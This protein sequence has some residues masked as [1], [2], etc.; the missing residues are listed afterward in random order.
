MIVVLLCLI[1]GGGYYAY[2]HLVNKNNAENEDS[3][4][5]KEDFVELSPKFIK[6]IEKY[7]QLGI[8]SEGYAAVCKDGKWGYHSLRRTACV[9]IGSRADSEA[10]RRCLH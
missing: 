3:S 4:N 8:F 5:S 6:A 1:G 2:T 9:D 7:D 10:D